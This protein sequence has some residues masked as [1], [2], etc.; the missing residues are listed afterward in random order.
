LCRSGY[1]LDNTNNTTEVEVPKNPDGSCPP[2]SHIVGFGGKVG[3]G[4]PSGSKCVSDNP[5]TQT[6][7]TMPPKEEIKC[8]EGSSPT[9]GGAL[10]L[11]PATALTL[12]H[13]ICPE[14]YSGNPPQC[15]KPSTTPTTPTPTPTQTTTPTPTGQTG[16]TTPNRSGGGGSSSTLSTTIINPASPTTTTVDPEVSNC[17]IDGNA[18]GIQQQFDKAKFSA[19][20]LYPTGQT[21]YSD[22]FIA[23]CTQAGNTQQMCMAF[24]QLNTGAQSTQTQ[25]PT[26]TQPTQAIPPTG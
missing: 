12:P 3:S 23:G 16:Q 21:A 5:S 9:S 22:G 14:G 2:G 19:C 18:N 7:T 24:I 20:G 25:P 8:P 26:T 10:C 6:P 11:V 15:V 13:Y 4:A 1:Y 17:R